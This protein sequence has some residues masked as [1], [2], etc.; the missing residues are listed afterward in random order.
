MA[1][2]DSARA[3]HGAIGQPDHP[4]PQVGGRPRI[5]G[6]FREIAEHGHRVLNLIRVE[7]TETLCTV[8]RHGATL[9][10]RLEF[11]VALPGSKQDGNV[12]RLRRPPDAGRPVLM[13]ACPIRR[14][15]S[16]ATAS[17]AARVVPPPTRPSQV[18]GRSRLLRLRPVVIVD[19]G[20]RS[21]SPCSNANGDPSATGVDRR[22]RRHRLTNA[23]SVGTDR[24]LTAIARRAS[25]LPRNPPTKCAA[26]SSSATSASRNP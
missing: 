18:G 12:G 2:R 5:G 23:S 22:R 21:W 4:G 9:E 26:S 7:E 11:A 13:I 16:S 10:G 19:Q 17:A 1:R 24:K 15:I 3:G 20:N 25:S 14:T 8:G 6:R